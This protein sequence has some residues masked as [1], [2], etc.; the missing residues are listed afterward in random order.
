MTG[1][2]RSAYR[3]AKGVAR[4][5]AGCIG[6]VTEVRTTSQC[7]VLTYDDGPEPEGTDRVLDALAKHQATATFF[8]LLTRARRYG[9]LLAEV[10]AAG[11]EVALH[12]IDHR[13]LT[14]FSYAQ[15]KQRTAD[16]RAELEDLTGRRI[17]WIRPP[18]GRQTLNT[19]RA[20]RSTGVMPVM[21][22]PTTWDSIDIAQSHRVRKAQ[23]GAVA[24]AILLAHDGFAGPQDGVDDGPPPVL[25]RGEF[26]ER[27]L[28]AYRARGLSGCSLAAALTQGSAVREARFRR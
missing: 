26:A 13:R 9:G 18:Y 28:E 22:G 5:H 15:V 10:V 20:I 19:W 14:D 1:V 27:V 21:W 23:E 24:G 7:I 2:A 8:V 6:S 4:R 3:A 25:D 16:G 12:G 17:E 11:H